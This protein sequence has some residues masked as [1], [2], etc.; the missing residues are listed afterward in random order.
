MDTSKVVKYYDYTLKYYKRFWY[1]DSKSYALHYG[2]WDKDTKNLNEALLNTNKFLAKK[3]DLKAKDRVLD[4][5][6]GIGGS[7]LWIAKK[8]GAKVVGVSISEKQINFA[9]ELARINNVEHLTEFYI[10]DFIDTGFENETFNVVWAIESVCHAENKFEFLKEA[11]R[12]L[13]KGGKIIIADGF[14]KRN[15][16]NDEEKIIIEKFNEGLV[17]PNLSD[18]DQFKKKLEKAGFKRIDYWDKTKEILPSS[19]K[20]YYMCKISYPFLKIGEK[21]KVTS[22]MLTNNNLSGI[23][24]YRAIRSGLGGYFVFY[25]EK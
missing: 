8:I 9:K 15:A 19:K 18:V 10:K 4:A 11:F 16:M 23:V 3:L 20:L 6:C 2:F 24:Q 12:V 25:G 22:P 21:L 1:R 5:G 14:L 17:L 7:S 13:R